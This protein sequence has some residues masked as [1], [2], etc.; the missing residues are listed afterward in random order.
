MEEEYAEPVG[1]KNY[2]GSALDSVSGLR[3]R[4]DGKDVINDMEITLRGGYVDRRG[5]ILYDETKR[6]MNDK[7]IHHARFMLQSAVNKI[8]HLTKYDNEDRI[9]KQTQMLARAW[10]FQVVKNR[11]NWEVTEPREAVRVIEQT[12]YE[13][14]LRGNDGFEAEL[15]T[16]SHNVNE[17]VTPQREQRESVFSRFF[18]GGRRI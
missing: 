17:V 7:G 15:I 14:M 4:L 18:G 13:S 1:Q 2:F 8:N 3:Y 10:I 12:I 5:K 9:Q 11:K 16:K 6:I